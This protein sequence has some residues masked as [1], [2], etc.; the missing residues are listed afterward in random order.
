MN[1]WTAA[2]VAVSRQRRKVG[3]A[4]LL[5]IALA[6]L[7]FLLRDTPLLGD[8]LPRRDATWQAMQT[9]GTWR[10]GIDPSFPPFEMLDADGQI[11]GL[12]AELAQAIA[13]SWGLDVE[14][15]PIGFD[16]LLDALQAG[17]V[18]SVVSALPFDERMT[19]NVAYSRPYFEAGIRLAVRAG[20]EMETVEDLQSGEDQAR[21]GQRQRVAVEWGSTGDLI[22]RQLQREGYAL[23][24]VPLQTP[25][26]VVDALRAGAA[27]GG[28]AVDAALVD[29]V[30]L[31]QAQYAA[32]GDAL[33]AVGPALESNPYV[34]AMPLRAA[35]LH[36][37]V[38]EALDALETGGALLELEGKWFGE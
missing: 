20:S 30:T 11:V 21:S 15:V 35:T 9:R 7:L 18:D 13:T 6:T 29:N 32:E 34:I 14:L 28:E 1:N 37:Q 17:R 36:E 5:L 23:T 19:R 10:V 27:A 12:D 24:L 33:V 22:G 38:A 3:L 16:G 8:L 25:V 31:K 2:R 4:V 26:E